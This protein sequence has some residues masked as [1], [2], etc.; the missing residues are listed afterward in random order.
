MPHRHSQPC[1]RP[2]RLSFAS[3]PAHGN[4]VH[5][6][7]CARPYSQFQD[8]LAVRAA[9]HTAG[10]AADVAASTRVQPVGRA[11]RPV[12]RT[13]S[14]VV[15]R[16]PRGLLRRHR[17]A[18]RGRS[19]HARR[20]IGRQRARERVRRARRVLQHATDGVV[21]ERQG[22]YD[23][24]QSVAVQAKV[25]QVV[26]LHEPSRNA[27][28]EKV[29][30]QTQAV[31]R[32]QRRNSV[33]DAT[34]EPVYVQDQEGETGQCRNRLGDHAAQ[35]VVP[36][37]DVDNVGTIGAATKATGKCVWIIDAPTRV[38]PAVVAVGPLRAAGAVE[39]LLPG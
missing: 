24:G 38:E 32:G 14:P 5:S 19:L 18:V 7:A 28:A 2:P 22:G 8:V 39:D 3:T 27:A 31:Q 9:G 17:N 4:V 33:R 23:A 34:R 15:Q 11:V 21:L 10:P 6:S 12:R 25:R 35:V 16:L 13:P 36:Q 1:A 26:E 29:F 37:V 20:R 30:V